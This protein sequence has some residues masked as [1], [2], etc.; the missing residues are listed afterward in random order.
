MIGTV[1]VAIVYILAT[2]VV[3][4]LVPAETLAKSPAPFADAA[5]L[6]WGEGASWVISVGAAVACFGALNGW[7]LL[8]GQL[9]LAMAEDGMFPDVFQRL[10]RRGAPFLGVLAT[11]ILAALLV[12]ANYTRSLVDLFTFSILLATLGTLVPYVFCS[13]AYMILKRGA[14]VSR[15]RFVLASAAFSYALWA[16]AGAGQEVVFWGFLCLL[17]GG[18]IYV[19]MQ[20]RPAGRGEPERP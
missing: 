14:G 16:I 7:T 10:N 8:G 11:S 5:R 17:G 20:R 3:Q 13:L 19:L 12:L 2:T 6:L 1:L 18:P 4:G 9:P 15:L